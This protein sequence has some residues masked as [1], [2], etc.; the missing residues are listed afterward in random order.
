M[1]PACMTT[2]ALV[3]AGATSTGGLIA[4]IANKLPAKSSAKTIDTPSQA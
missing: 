3:V 2:A 1:C 4:L